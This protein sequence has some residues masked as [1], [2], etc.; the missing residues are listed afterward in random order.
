MKN[1]DLIQSLLPGG[2]KSTFRLLRIHGKST[3]PSLPDLLFL[4]KDRSQFQKLLQ[5]VRISARQKVFQR[6]DL[7]DL[8]RF[9]PKKDPARLLGIGLLA[10]ADQIVPIGTL[11]S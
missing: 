1:S 5:P 6:N 8:S 4:Q 11:K 10:Q 3:P 7:L 2:R 9:P